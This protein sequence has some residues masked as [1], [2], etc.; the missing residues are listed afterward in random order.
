MERDE[1]TWEKLI[2]INPRIKGGKPVIKGTRVPVEVIV[3]ALA[4]GASWEEVGE[5]YKVTLEQV[6]ACL[7]FAAQMLANEMVNSNR[8]Y[9]VFF[10]IPFDAATMQMYDQIHQHLKDEYGDRLQFAYGTDRFVEP[11]PDFLRIESFKAQNKD[12]LGRFYSH[13]KSADIVVADLTNNNPNVHLELGIALSLNKNILRLSGRNLIQLASDVKQFDVSSYQNEEELR[14]RIVKYLNM[15]LLIKEQPLSEK[16]RLLY[17]LQFPSG[18]TVENRQYSDPNIFGEP[19]QNRTY[20]QILKEMRDFEVKVRFK[21]C[22]V[23]NEQHWF[24]AC[25]RYGTEPWYGGGYLLHLRKNGELVLAKMPSVKYLGQKSYQPLD[26]D[27]EYIFHFR[28]DGYHL[29]ASLDD[30]FR[31][32]LEIYDLDDQSYGG[33]A[34]GCLGSRVHFRS[35]ETICRDTLDFTQIGR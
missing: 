19:N 14:T 34:L 27:K 15:F 17:H 6:R 5:A 25:F 20:E 9:R 31:D 26:L 4:G 18:V 29:T 24:G 3:G 10:A 16:A 22:V 13:I 11:S 7:A 21:F 23:G 12:L 30:G 1:E 28:V 33:V 35:V 32:P 2:E 8:F